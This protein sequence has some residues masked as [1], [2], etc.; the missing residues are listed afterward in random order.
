M[1]TRAP[2]NVNPICRAPTPIAAGE[3]KPGGTDLVEW[4]AADLA[5]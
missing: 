4:D 5:W 1:T 2:D 3:A